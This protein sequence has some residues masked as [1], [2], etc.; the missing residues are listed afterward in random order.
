MMKESCTR[1]SILIV[2]LIISHFRTLNTGV[3]LL[4][5][6]VETVAKVSFEEFCQQN[7]FEPMSMENTSWFLK[8][9]DSSMV[10]K[11]YVHKNASGLSFTSGFQFKGHNGYPDY[12]AGQL[13]TSIADFSVLLVGYSNSENSTFILRKETTNQITPVP[14]ISQEG[15]YTWFLKS[16]GDHLYYSHGGGDTGVRTVAILDV[17]SKNGIAI[18]ANAA[19]DLESLLSEIEAKMWGE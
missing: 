14:Q 2:V 15:Y 8:N 6:I 11:T 10:A 19:Y 5:L 1:K 9:L 7:I 4:G 13:R 12:P 3:A 17:N 18:F 16:M